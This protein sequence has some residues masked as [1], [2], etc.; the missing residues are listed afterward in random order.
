MCRFTGV[1][2]TKTQISCAEADQRLCFRF[3][4]S[5]IPLFL[6]KYELLSFKPFSVTLQTCLCQTCS[7]TRMS[8]GFSRR[9]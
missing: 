5:T 3:T 9:G 1:L 4:D 8:P 6:T 7:E 2:S